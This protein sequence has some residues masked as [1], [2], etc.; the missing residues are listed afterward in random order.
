M[1][2]S[3]IRP[4]SAGLRGDL[5]LHARARSP[6]PL[7]WDRD[8][9][10]IGRLR[11]QRPDRASGA[12]RSHDRRRARADRAL[13]SR[14]LGALREAS[15]LGMVTGVYVLGMVQSAGTMWI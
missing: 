3:D 5:D 9:R 14:G 8:A 7:R 15:A 2:S 13:G 6:G 12:R 4:P 1:I 11:G 10:G